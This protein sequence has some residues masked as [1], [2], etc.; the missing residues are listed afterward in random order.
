MEAYD[1]FEKKFRRMKSIVYHNSVIITD[2]RGKIEE[3]LPSLS[4]RHRSPPY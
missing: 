1:K 2:K 4:L 3:I